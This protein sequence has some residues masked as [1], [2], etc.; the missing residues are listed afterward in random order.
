MLNKLTEN[1]KKLAKKKLLTV[2]KIIK[3]LSY[4]PNFNAEQKRDTRPSEATIVS[5]SMDANLKADDQQVTLRARIKKFE[6]LLKA[7]RTSSAAYREKLGR[8]QERYRDMRAMVLVERGRVKQTRDERNAAQLLA[9]EREAANGYFQDLMSGIGQDVAILRFVEKSSEGSGRI[10]ARTFAHWMY[11][12]PE[13]KQFGAIAIGS[14]L[15]SDELFGASLSYFK[16]AG[17]KNAWRLV[18]IEVMTAILGD[19]VVDGMKDCQTWLD[20]Q[21]VST[22]SVLLCKVLK[23]FIRFGHLDEARELCQSLSDLTVNSNGLNEDQVKEFAWMSRRLIGGRDENNLAIDSDTVSIAVMDYKLVDRQR[24]SSNRGDY[25]Q[26]LAA[27]SN[28]LRFQDVEFVGGSELDHYL[29]KQKPN[30]HEDRVITLGGRPV[31]AAALPLDR[32][33]ASG[34]QYPDNTWLLCNGWFMHRN[35]KGNIDFPFP[36][37]INPIFLSFHL[38]DAAVMDVDVAEQ[39]KRYAPIGCRDWTTV[40]RLREFG[41]SCFFSG[42]L[43]TTIG[44]IMPKA[45][46]AQEKA[47]ALVESRISSAKTKG[48]RVD[49]FSQ[50]GDYVRE[51]SLVEGLRDADAMLR[52]YLPYSKIKTSRLHCYLPCRSMGFDVDFAPRNRSDIRFEGIL[53]LTPEALLKIR[54]GCETKLAAVFTEIFKGKSQEEVMQV[55]REICADDVAAADVYINDY[56]TPPVSDEKTA[57]LVSKIKTSRFGVEAPDAIH[58]A[59]AIDQNVMGYLPV[60]LQS[61]LDH[62]SRPLVVH[63]MHRDLPQDYLDALPRAYPGIAFRLYDMNAVDYGENLKMLKH[64]TVSTMDRCL[65]PEMISAKNKVVYLDVD[66]LVR[67]DLA[68]IYD[69]DLT[70]HFVAGKLS[71]LK[72]WSLVV[73][74]ATRGSLH[75]EPEA[76]WNLRRML[77]GEHNLYQTSFNAGMVVMNLKMMREKNF[78]GHAMNLISNCFFNDQDVLNIFGASSTYELDL[79][80]NYVPAQDYCLDPKIVHWA[81]TVKP[82]G[83]ELVLWKDEFH[84]VAQRAKEVA[85]YTWRG[86]LK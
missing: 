47:L 85:G 21:D 10:M 72:T 43:T 70:N 58:T 25:V 81:G 49:E 46:Q 4:A 77:H 36:K 13:R 32:D 52:G 83:S 11:Q 33:F 69:I 16:E 42:C 24:T 67:A 79:S 74:L 27:L 37:T 84:A 28:I 18:P 80:W 17:L 71:N 6:T 23:V 29:N 15:I 45:D 14:F 57:T 61:V 60:V 40:Y 54:T 82:W 9:N 39:L 76:A 1:K 38:N 50:I 66:I 75:L 48:W 51:F 19:N 64:T 68:E 3:N 62:A 44:Q 31:K 12:N 78:S 2:F 34:R 35:F 7:A 22:N 20:K 26:T 8:A 65:L 59:F 73:K 53:D 55:W 30:I 56:P 63:L 41:V 86:D 5:D